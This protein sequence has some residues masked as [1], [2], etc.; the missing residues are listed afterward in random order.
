MW[1][2]YYIQR[3]QDMLRNNTFFLNSLHLGGHYIFPFDL[4]SYCCPPN[5]PTSTSHRP[6][7]HAPV[8]ML[9]YFWTRPSDHWSWRPTDPWAMV[10]SVSVAKAMVY[11]SLQPYWRLMHYCTTFSIHGEAQ[12]STDGWPIVEPESNWMWHCCQFRC[13]HE[14]RWLI[15]SILTNCNGPPNAKTPWH[16]YQR[17]QK[18]AIGSIGVYIVKI[19]YNKRKTRHFPC[20]RYIEIW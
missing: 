17:E 14:C 18:N 4:P 9:F 12:C 6:Y 1:L 19:T 16:N 11:V 3:N 2:R 5:I 13:H 7:R 10:S 15:F 8:P 20:P